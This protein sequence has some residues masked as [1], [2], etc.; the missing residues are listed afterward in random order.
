[1]ELNTAAKVLK[2]AACTFVQKVSNSSHNLMQCY[3][4]YYWIYEE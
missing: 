1:M 2:H 3:I 4:H